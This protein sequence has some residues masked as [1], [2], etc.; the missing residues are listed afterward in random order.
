MSILIL[1]KG[2][3]IER[4]EGKDQDAGEVRHCIFAHKHIKKKK[5]TSTCKTIHT[6]HLLNAGR[7]TENSKKGQETLDLTG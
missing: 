1:V 3:K 4:G 7:R 6:E 2:N 5:N